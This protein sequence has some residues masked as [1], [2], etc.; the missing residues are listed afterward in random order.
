MNDVNCTTL[1]LDGDESARM[2]KACEIAKDAKELAVVAF[3]AVE[4][5]KAPVKPEKGG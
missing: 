1:D 5:V 2:L 3:V 4:P